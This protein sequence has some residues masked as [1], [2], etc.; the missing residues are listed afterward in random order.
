MGDGLGSTVQFAGGAVGSGVSQ[1]GNY[2]TGAKDKDGSAADSKLSTAS[3]SPA[4]RAEREKTERK[5]LPDG[6]KGKEHTSQQISD[7][8]KNTQ[9]KGS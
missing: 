4:T 5:I 2:V 7:S 3:E 6:Y 8:V 1:V 9:D